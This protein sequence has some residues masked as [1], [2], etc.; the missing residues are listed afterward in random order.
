MR[1]VALCEQHGVPLIEDDT[2]SALGRDDAPLRALKS[3]D[4]TGNVIHCAS[5]RKTIAPGLRLGWVSGGRWQARIR[6]LRYAQSRANEA[7]P[8]LTMAE[9]MAS[10]SYD[11]H[12]ARLRR[13][14]R[15][16]RE[17]TADAIATHW[18]A[19]TKL[20]VP[21]GSMMLWVELPDRR[22]GQAVFEAALQQGIRVAPGAL[23]SNSNRF[24]HF[25]RISCGAAFTRE[26]EEAL[27][28]LGR[29]VA[30]P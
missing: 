12:L 20:S 1:L 5:L 30:Q 29:I 2:Y 7:L 18:P 9:F 28:R 14:L 6:M 8:Q 25:L 13:V 21:E 27:Q 26:A 10:S 23:F 24:D 19:G 22:D 11:R 4:E 15:R 17:Q 16:Q 3:W